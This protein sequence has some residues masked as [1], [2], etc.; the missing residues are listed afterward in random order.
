MSSVTQYQIKLQCTL[1][2]NIFYSEELLNQHYHE[3]DMISAVTSENSYN[4]NCG[5]MLP[6]DINGVNKY[7]IK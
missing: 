1:R 7:T 6:L 4:T 5:K 3:E 2:K